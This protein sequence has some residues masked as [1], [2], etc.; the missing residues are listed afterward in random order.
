MRSGEEKSCLKKEDLRL[1]LE[2]LLFVATIL[3]LTP[4][5]IIEAADNS[6]PAFA[7]Q[8]VPNNILVDAESALSL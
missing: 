5:S 7:L 6:L 8:I 2:P 3:V 1:L 4:E